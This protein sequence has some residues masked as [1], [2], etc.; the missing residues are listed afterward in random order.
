MAQDFTACE[1]YLLKLGTQLVFHSHANLHTHLV[2]VHG[3]LKR[4]GCPERVALAGLFHSIYSTDEFHDF[5]LPLT[6][7][8]KIKNLI[9]EQAERLVYMYSAATRE[10]WR[11]SALS[12]GRPQLIDRLTGAPLDVTEQEFTDLLWLWL[13]NNLDIKAREMK[14]NGTAVLKRAN[15]YRQVAERLG[16]RARESWQEVY[17]VNVGGASDFTLEVRWHAARVRRI[18]ISRIKRLFGTAKPFRRSA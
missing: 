2:G 9:G 1:G 12:G 3:L 16:D 8:G 4:W 7:R 11:R 10:S 17:G 13:A 6:E 14:V 18:L 15:F 5:A